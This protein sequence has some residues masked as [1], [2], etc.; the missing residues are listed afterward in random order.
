[1]LDRFT[2]RARKVMSLAKQEAIDLKS[3]KVGTEHLLLALAKEEDGIAAE[4]L[5][6]LDIS[7]DDILE[8][9]KEIR[10]TIPAE[11]EPAE[12]AKLAFTP[13]VISVMERSFR[14]AR[15]NNQT[16]VSTEHLLLAIVSEG[17]GLAMDIFQRLGVSGASVRASVERLTAKDQ[18]GKRPMAGAGAGRPGAGL[19]FFSGEAG[20]AGAKIAGGTLEQFAINLCRRAR[21][22]KLDPVIGREKEISRMM[23]ILSRRTKNNP[24][25]LGDPG[26]GKTAL[27]E[28]LA[29][30]IVAGNVPENL[31]NMNIWALDLPGLV[32]GAKYRGE[33]EERLKNVIA[34]CTESDNAILFIDEMH[35]LIGAGSA[36]GSIDA[37][38]MLK[39]VLAR[40]A[41]QIIGATT[42]EEFRKYLTKDP[43]FERRFQSID[44]EE[45]S[46]EDTVTILKALVPRYEEH[47]H[48]RYTP[49]AIEA[50][51]SLSNRYIQ[52]RYLPDKA[53]DLIDEAGARARIA[54]NRAP[55]EVRD[56]EKRVTELSD[57]VEAASNDDDMNRAAEL[58]QDQQAAEIAL[59]E[60]RAAWN[61]Q[62]DADPLVIDTAQIADIVSITSGVPVSSLTESESRRLLQCESVLKTRIIGQDE[63][64]SAVAKAIRRSRSPLKDPRRP[65][66]SFIFLGPTGTGKTELAKTLAEYLFG[67]KDALISFDMSEFGSEFEVSKLI[68]SPPGYVGHDEGG[69]LTKAVR[70]HPYSVVLFDEVEKAHP[71]IF[72]ILLQVLEEGRLTDGQGKTV[73]FRNTVVIMTSNV[74][75]R[76]I[77][78]ES[79]VGFGTTGENGL[80]SGE[81]RSRAMGE[82]K[83]LFRPEF[84]NRIDDIVVFQKLTGEDLKSIAQLLV[85]DLRQRLIANGMNIELTDAAIDKIVAEGTDLTNGARPLRR[86][87]QRLIEDP[88]SE[89]LL[90]G[91]W[92]EG[93]TVLCDVADE[94]FVF[95]HGTGEI[96]APRALGALGSSAV[97]A[98]HT[99]GAAPSTGVTAGPGGMMQTGSG[100]H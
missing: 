49:A 16:Y 32:A 44:V 41:F 66:G 99:S 80:S 86:A 33:F 3:T 31:L 98:P 58:K 45:P 60:A 95:S 77:A 37:S 11:D 52:D 24:L 90:A 87:I 42:A 83:R 59:G 71:D 75:A 40:G 18:G 22:G 38:S 57:A 5:R 85:D 19:P 29:Q 79:N 68:G 72:N 55:Q 10:T 91:E 1:M 78:Q 30:E 35:T 34:E 47:H 17:N 56:A 9:L 4:A 21:E 23:E 28:G 100:A 65:G 25:I 6:A 36:E 73:D 62:M 54:A 26:V 13:L 93:D 88:L 7:Y 64:V 43:A 97:A 69:Q 74:G 84:L 50:A 20:I 61:A 82:L 89:E 39:P 14:L 12:A 2:D 27:V 92:G 8:Q 96:P 81:I 76:E 67:S 15:E 70:R 63:A 48:V 94:K 53:I 46:V 51:A